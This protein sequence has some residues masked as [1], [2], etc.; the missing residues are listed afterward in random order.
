[1]S[2]A[3]PHSDQ[4]PEEVEDRIWELSK[5]IDIC[6]FTTWDGERQR[7]RPLSARVDRDKHAIYFL[8]DQDGH[9]NGQ[10]ERFPIVTMTWTDSGG[11]KYVTMT[12]EA[13]VANDRALIK[14]LWSNFDKAWW[15]DE[16]DP[17]IRVLTV[18]P[19][20][21]ELWDSPNQLV[22]STKM[23]VAAVTGASPDFGDNAK[24]QL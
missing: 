15:E 18:I 22:A 4:T 23:L 3:Q 21:G 5:K 16:N 10:I 7:A 11:H 19:D 17:S 8:V 13:T 9:K 6:M 14:D 24:V 12:G 1:M 2:K 20:D